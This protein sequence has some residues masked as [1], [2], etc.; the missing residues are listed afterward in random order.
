MYDYLT[1]EQ[2]MN[3]GLNYTKTREQLVWLFRQ[4]RAWSA[5][6]L[7]TKIEANLSTIYRNLKHFEEAK[8]IEA[9]F[10]RGGETV[11]EYTKR[12]HHDHAICESCETPRCIPCPVSTSKPHLLQLFETCPSCK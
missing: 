9:V 6:Q 10:E 1:S 7:A 11:Y 3:V 2:L 8:L 12:T 4:Q 5:S